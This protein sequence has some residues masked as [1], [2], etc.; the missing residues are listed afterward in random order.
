M[1]TTSLLFIILAGINIGK[2]YAGSCCSSIKPHSMK[3][4]KDL[5]KFMS[6]EVC[7]VLDLCHYK[8]L[9]R[10]WCET[11]WYLGIYS[12][13]HPLSGIHFSFEA[14]RTHPLE[15]FLHVLSRC[16]DHSAMQEHVSHKALNQSSL[17]YWNIPYA[18]QGH[19]V[20]VVLCLSNFCPLRLF[21]SDRNVALLNE[22]GRKRKGRQRYAGFIYVFIYFQSAGFNY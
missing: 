5:S 3:G 18:H 10:S 22:K 13:W 8:T 15:L 20:S 4:L 11:E 7:H 21:S 9:A 6:Q 19:T 2:M 16:Q 17:D 1:W 14:V 12:S